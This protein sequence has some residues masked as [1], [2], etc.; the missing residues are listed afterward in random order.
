MQDLYLLTLPQLCCQDGG[1]KTDRQ[2]CHQTNDILALSRVIK[3]AA[4]TRWNPLSPPLHSKWDIGRHSALS[5]VPREDISKSMGFNHVHPPPNKEQKM[6]RA[7]LRLITL[8]GSEMLMWVSRH[9]LGNS[10][11]SE[12]SQVHCTAITHNAVIMAVSVWAVHS[13]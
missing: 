6:S 10:E 11:R 12:G 2:R 1:V 9:H 7:Q 4:P 5:S 13:L 3:K 8:E